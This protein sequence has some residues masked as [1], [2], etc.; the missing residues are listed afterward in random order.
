[1]KMVLLSIKPEYCK[2]IF[3]QEKK[4]EYR[5]R[6]FKEKVDTLLIYESNPT[7]RIVGEVPILGVLKGTP[8]EIWEKTEKFGGIT[9]AEFYRYFLHSEYAYAIQL[10]I[11][12]KYDT[13]RTL[14][15]YGIRRPPQ[16]F[17]YVKEYKN[18]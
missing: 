8:L 10:G 14:D 13:P 17:C 11:P 18:S 4:V 7:K 3:S 9:E 2:K 16:S 12:V 5:K 1:M 6:I 15:E